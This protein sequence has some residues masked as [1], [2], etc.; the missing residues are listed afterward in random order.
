M[1]LGLMQL[2]L[3]FT[4]MA[5]ASVH[6]TPQ[7]PVSPNWLIVTYFFHTTGE[8]CLSPIGLSSTTKL[9]PPRYA[10]QMMGIWFMGAA[11]GNLVAGRVAGLIDSLPLPELFGA[12][13][14]FSMGAGLLLLIFTRPL[15]TW[16]EGVE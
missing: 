13:T 12:V 1:A 11:L 15:K 7:H 14:L 5:W 4:V 2:G 10:A 9:A 6:A 16:M 3:G 8:L